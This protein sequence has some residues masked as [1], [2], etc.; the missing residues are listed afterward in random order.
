MRFPGFKPFL[1]N[2]TCTATARGF[3]ADGGVNGAR[4]GTHNHSRDA[5][6]LEMLKSAAKQ[7]IHVINAAQHL[8]AVGLLHK[9]NSVV[10]HSLKR[11]CFQPL[12]PIK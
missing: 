10:T 3:L 7:T 12:Q 4:G 6:R 9:A 5:S 1:S 2:A 8:P 11:A